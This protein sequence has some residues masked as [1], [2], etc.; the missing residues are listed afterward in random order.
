MFREP[1]FHLCVFDKRY[2]MENVSSFDDET[3]FISKSRRIRDPAGIWIFG[4]SSIQQ[5]PTWVILPLDHHVRVIVGERQ[6]VTARPMSLK[7]LKLSRVTRRL[8][9]VSRVLPRLVPQDM[10]C[11]QRIPH[12]EPRG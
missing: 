2:N 5:S 7:I 10:G 1:T 12:L 9:R 4:R 6:E 8:S 3:H 11:S